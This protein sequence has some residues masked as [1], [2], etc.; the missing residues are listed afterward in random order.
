MRSGFVSVVLV[1]LFVAVP[2][3][4]MFSEELEPLENPEFAPSVPFDI[5]M[6]GNSY[7]SANNLANLVQDGLVSGGVSATVDSLTGGGM[8]LDGHSQNAQ[9]SGHSWNTTLNDGTVWDYVVLQDQSQ[10]PGF[11]RNTAYFI[12]DNMT[13]GSILARLQVQVL[14][15]FA[16]MLVQNSGVEEMVILTIKFFILIS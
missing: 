6:Y 14:D 8:T 3:G 1:L 16:K 10:I 7:T 12:L 11:Y 9:S 4:Q 15:G 5:L 13:W 2:F